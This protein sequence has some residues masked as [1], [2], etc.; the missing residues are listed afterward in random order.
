MP[1]Q[2]LI[3]NFDRIRGYMRDFFIYGCKTRSDRE[4]ASL[5]TY[6]NE[7]RRIE[8]Y[9]GDYMCFRL[10]EGGRGKRVWLSM[11]SAA[12]E[13]NPFYQAYRSKSFTD[14]DIILHFYL[15]EA[16]SALEPPQ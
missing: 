15:L 5:R 13:R 4:E 9:L 11:E 16:L 1:F 10:R 8:S 14:N 12:L 3:K 2:E 6:D 7:R